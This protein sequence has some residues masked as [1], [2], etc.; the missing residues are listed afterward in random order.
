MEFVVYVSV[1]VAIIA[2]LIGVPALIWGMYDNKRRERE[3][4]EEAAASA[5]TQC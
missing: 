5:I 4:Q 2:F 3:Q 1:G